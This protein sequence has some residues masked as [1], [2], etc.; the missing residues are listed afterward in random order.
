MVM[1]KSFSALRPMKQWAKEVAALPYDV[2]DEQTAK[3]MIQ[4]QPYSFLNIDLPELHVN[5]EGEAPYQYAGKQLKERIKKGIFIKDSKALYIY[6]MQTNAVHQYG[7]VGLVS[8]KDYGDGN[9]KKHENT[10]QMKEQERIWHIIHC[11]AHTGPV[12][13]VNRYTQ[14][15][16]QQLREYANRHESLYDETYEDGVTHRIYKIVENEIIQYWIQQLSQVPA[17]YIADGHHRAAAAYKVAQTIGKNM[18]EAQ[19]FLAVIFPKDELQILPY[20]RIVKDE[21]GY[22]KDELLDKLRLQFNISVVKDELYLPEQPH[23]FGM[24]YDGI[25]Y[26]LRYK[27]S[28]LKTCSKIEGL[29]ASILQN[30]ILEPIFNIK[31]PKEDSRLRF[32][33]GLGS[34][35]QLNEQTENRQFIAFSLYPTSVDDVMAIADEGGLMPPKST[36]FEPK[37]RSG[38]LIHCFGEA[39]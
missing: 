18:E 21:S 25:W 8:A 28:N 23:S 13:L 24:R 26:E 15:F 2:V 5:E 30:E 9:I 34:E 38:F 1:L 27:I 3:W 29:D 32:I 16:G 37:L 22:T 6:E 35:R 10:R 39:E 31:H 17:L 20:H 36:W 7:L 12:Y 4:Q 14:R 19:D 33:A 11:K